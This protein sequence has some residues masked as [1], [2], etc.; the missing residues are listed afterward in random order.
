MVMQVL[1]VFLI[2]RASA[3]AQ[4]RPQEGISA[5]ASSPTDTLLNLTRATNQASSYLVR[6]CSPRGRFAYIVDTEEGG[7][8]RSYNIVRHAGAIFEFATPAWPTSIL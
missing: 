6:A 3:M 1:V 7:V 4:S 2:V 8:S 5:N